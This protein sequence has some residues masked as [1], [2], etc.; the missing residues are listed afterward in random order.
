MKGKIYLIIFI[1]G[2]ICFLIANALIDFRE[3]METQMIAGADKDASGADKGTSAS[4]ADKGA[5]E[6]DKGASGAGASE[7][8]KD[9]DKENKT[10]TDP[11]A[12]KAEIR[13][14]LQFDAM[15]AGSLMSN[16]TQAQTNEMKNIM[17]GSSA[18][19]GSQSNGVV[20]AGG[21][22]TLG[23]FNV[24]LAVSPLDPNDKSQLPPTSGPSETGTAATSEAVES[25]LDTLLDRGNAQ[26][27]N[28]ST[29]SP[30]GSNT[31]ND[32]CRQNQYYSSDQRSCEDCF[33]QWSS[34]M[35][36]CFESNPNNEYWV[37]G[38][39]STSDT[40]GCNI[41]PTNVRL[42]SSKVVSAHGVKVSGQGSAQLVNNGSLGTGSYGS[43]WSFSDVSSDDTREVNW[44][45]GAADENFAALN[46]SVT[47]RLGNCDTDSRS[48]KWVVARTGSKMVGENG[49]PALE[50]NTNQGWAWQPGTVSLLPT[51]LTN[52][53]RLDSSQTN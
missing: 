35:L 17:L 14:Q 8:D 51:I 3:G 31:E 4:E 5:S 16:A 47:E 43:G 9:A 37:L 18:V 48:K 2:L 1:I 29:S 23:G 7:A 50:N 46:G 44:T 28:Q 53:W 24:C 42:A 13:K 32:T 6:A 41:L 38:I 21:S 39:L 30:Q 12:E 22:S 25:P 36:S 19:P 20:K 40:S 45:I 33:G 15:P 10:I 34:E 52:G 49:Y 26:S 27:G 11:D